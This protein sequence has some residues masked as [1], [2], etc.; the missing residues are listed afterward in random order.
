MHDNYWLMPLVFAGIASIRLIAL[1][2]KARAN[3]DRIE[4]FGTLPYR[5]VILLGSSG[6]AAV[7]ITTWSTSEVWVRIGLAIGVFAIAAGWPSTINIDKDKVTQEWWWGRRVSVL[8]SE[9]SSVEENGVGE[10]QVYGDDGR[11]VRFSRYLVDS[12]RF[13]QEVRMRAHVKVSKAGD[14]ISIT[15]G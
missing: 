5:L 2:S 4:F 11:A 7:L 14:P 12:E 15:K 1:G 13:R 8:W 6:A 9:V 3:G 10:Y